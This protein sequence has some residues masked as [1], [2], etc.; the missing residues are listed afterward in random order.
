MIL[1][2][3]GVI[4]T[5][6]VMMALEGVCVG[7]ELWVELLSCICRSSIHCS[8]VKHPH[9]YHIVWLIWTKSTTDYPRTV[10]TSRLHDI[11]ANLFCPICGTR[12]GPRRSQN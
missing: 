9:R 5:S 11:C 10:T 12:H 1:S 6:E 2:H 4:R 8:I 3:P 7:V